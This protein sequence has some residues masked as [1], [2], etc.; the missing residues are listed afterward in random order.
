[1]SCLEWV[2]LACWRVSGTG[3]GIETTEQ[4]PVRFTSIAAGDFHSLAVTDEGKV[5]A[6]GYNGFGQLGLGTTSGYKNSP[7]LITALSN[8][9]V[10]GIAA[11]DYHSLAFTTN[12]EVYAWGYNA[13]GQLGLGTSGNAYN[14]SS[15]VLITAL[16]NVSGIFAG[17]FH[18]L[19]FTTNGEV[20]AWG[21]N[22][23]G[24]LGLGTSGDASNKNSPVL[25]T[26]LSNITVSGIAAG[27]YHSLALTTNGEVYA[28]GRNSYGQL[29]LGTGGDANNE[30]SPDLI[31]TT[32]LS[33]VSGIA[34]GEYHS[35]AF[36]DEWRS[37]C[38]GEE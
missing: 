19:A 1:M 3:I 5:Y 4:I 35:L 6:W 32:A 22:Y 18:S 24:Q 7:V 15:P 2:V 9:T 29:G 37:L 34:A 8:I 31:P 23:F 13:W 20:Y 28:W 36:H 30:S 27:Y 11:G 21:Y 17:R 33:N 26:A 10:S 38:L 12:G 14:E 25:I 16:S